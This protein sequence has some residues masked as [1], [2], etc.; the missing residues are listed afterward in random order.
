MYLL[1]FSANVTTLYPDVP[2]LER[3]GRARASGFKYVECQ[4]PYAYSIAE[5]QAQLQENELELILF[6]LP[7][8]DWQQ[9]ERGL[10]VNP[11]RREEFR[12]SVAT[13]LRY[14][15]A[16]GCQRLH[17]MAGILPDGLEQEEAYEVLYDNMRY[18][19][20]EAE[21]QGI[22]ILIEPINQIDMP[23]Y[24][25]SSLGLAERLIRE[26][27]SPGIGLQFDFYHI[28]RIQG[29]LLNSYLKMSPII[30]H[31][32]IADNPG[33]HQP[34]TG[35]INYVKIFETIQATGYDGFIGCE[36][37]PLG[38]TDDSFRWLQEWQRGEV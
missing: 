28:Q 3:F 17:C 23:G 35:E 33:R 1:R 32:Q 15:T 24:Y 4:F 14:A 19:A 37:N 20:A 12:E 29:E 13:A 18:A 27:N 8:G 9:G 10:A 31:I 25:M 30:R 36:Y 22:T 38:D 16:L 6:N 34:G 7:P 5:L 11:K 2:F 26:L 21:K